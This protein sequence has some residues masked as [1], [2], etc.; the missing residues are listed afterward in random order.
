MLIGL[1]RLAHG[2]PI[3]T[4]RVDARR[5]DAETDAR[6]RENASVPL[7]TVIDARR[8]G[9]A[10]ASVADLLSSEAGVR[11]RSRGGLGAFTS[12]SLRGSEEGEVT[13]L[14]DGIP[15]SRAASGAIDLSTVPADG[16]ER[17]EIYRGAPP[18]QLG[19][20]AVGGVINLV[21]R[22]ATTKTSFGGEV[23]GGSFGARSV[24]VQV[25]G[26]VTRGKRPSQTL[27]AQASA[28]YHGATGDFTYFDNGGTLFDRTDDRTAQ[29]RNND[30][31]QGNVDVTLDRG[32]ARPLHVGV[33]GFI[34]D[35]G[36]PGVATLGKETEHARLRTSRL[37]V[38]GSAGRKGRADL[39][40]QTSL[41][42]ERSHFENPL[43]EAAGP[44][45]P[46]ITEGEAITASLVPR[47]D[48]PIGGRQFWSTL[49]ELRLED[50]KPYDLL[51]P[52]L[53]LRPAIRGLFALAASDELSLWRDRLAIYLGLRF[54]ARVS[55]LLEGVSG[56]T[57]P[58]QERFDWFLSP[59]LNVRLRA[60]R[61]V[62]LRGSVGRYVRFPT[63]LEQFGDGA[64]ILGRP[65]LRPESSWGGELAATLRGR[66][67]RV[68]GGLEAALFGRRVADLITYVPGGNTVSP[69][70]IG[71]A[72][73]LGLEARA[74]LAIAGHVE[75]AASYT[76]LDARDRT[77]DA[78]SEG[79]RLP[80][81]A[82]HALDARVTGICGPVR[83]GYEL[84]Y[85]S[86][87]PRDVLELNYLPARLLHALVAAVRAGRFEVTLEVRNLADTRVVQLPLGGIA[88]AGE[89]SPYALVDFY[90]F[91][92]PGRAFYATARFAQ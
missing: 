42:Y 31:N 41:L 79:H 56:E 32:G 75:L 67:R 36:V 90:N 77:D 65:T 71:D 1:G 37:L 86:A 58:D 4:V 88:R 7:V 85:L 72:Q 6:A 61:L 35:Q 89:T 25:G 5:P 68:A 30:F 87:V 13:V 16:L 15:L 76:F 40:V 70:N 57:L 49:A 63:L 18:V 54:D 2:D 11:I 81:R 29:R 74:D 20:E 59:R 19:G 22:R 39:H 17:I 33:H 26:P 14:L 10:Q 62:T 78:P 55:S 46:S 38:T 27:T 3:G 66:A 64:F 69:I 44:S 82:P 91:P 50:R 83:V 28:A 53:S 34:K 12:V 45:G 21:S 48:L 73:V 80:G 60:H 8:P 47:V 92:L 9:A 23:G 52:A 24:A 43:G 84:D 51:R